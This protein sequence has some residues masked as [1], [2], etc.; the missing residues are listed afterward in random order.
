[1]EEVPERNEAI[2]EGPSRTDKWLPSARVHVVLPPAHG[3]PLADGL[4]SCIG[5]RVKVLEYGVG[6]PVQET[7]ADENRVLRERWGWA[8]RMGGLLLV[9][10]LPPGHPVGRRPSE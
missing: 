2:V 3:D 4:P 9:I 7:E 10:V 6:D 8:K 5:I 1:M